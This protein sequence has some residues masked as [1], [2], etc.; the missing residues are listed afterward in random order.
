MIILLSRPEY[1]TIENIPEYVLDNHKGD[2][3]QVSLLFITLCRISGIP[4][5][6]QSGFM[7]H[8]KAW[9]LTTGRKSILKALAGFL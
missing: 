6:F 5:H 4:A 1:S 9:N 2:C 7:M 8:P 3:G